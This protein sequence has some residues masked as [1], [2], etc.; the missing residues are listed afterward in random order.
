M[1]KKILVTL[2]RNEVAPRFD[3]ASEVLLVTLDAEGREA[4]RQEL[5]LAHSSADDLCD[6]I[7]DREVSVVITGG[8]EEEHYH[9]LRWKRL[10]VIDGI[11]GLAE[12][13]LARYLSGSLESGA[14]LF[15]VG[16][17]GAKLPAAGGGGHA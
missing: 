2:Y 9:Y 3:L 16:A 8:M 5:V 12:D 15:P 1:S 4:K 6:L 10:E 13:A 14:M 11:A 17:P 7:L